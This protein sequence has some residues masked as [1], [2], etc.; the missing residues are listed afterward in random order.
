MEPCRISPTEHSS[1]LPVVTIEGY[2]AKEG[3]QALVTCVQGLLKSS[4]R[5]IVLDFSACSL[6]SSPGVASL[7]EIVCLIQE[8]HLGKCVLVG[9]DDP[10]RKF[11]AMTGILRLAPEVATIDDALALLK[12][13]A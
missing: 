11:L 13:T 8:D 4:R 5:K 3:G 1:G 9:L 12:P 10:K 6:V 2:L 7:L